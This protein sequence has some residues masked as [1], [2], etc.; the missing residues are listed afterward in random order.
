MRHPLFFAF[1]NALVLTATARIY[2]SCD[3]PIYCE[4]PLLRTV[5]LSNIFT[6][7]KTFVDRPTAKPVEE[8]LKA[9]Q[10]LGK[11]PSVTDVRMFVDENFLEPGMELSQVLIKSNKQPQILERVTD[12]AYSVWMTDLNQYWSNLTYT[13]NTTFLCDGCQ[14]SILPTKR[15]FVVP[16]GRFREFYYWDSY[17]VI[18]GLLYSELN[19][20]ARGMIENFL[21]FVETYGF[22]PNGARIYYLNRSQPPFLTRMIKRYLDFVDDEELFTRALPILDIEYEFWMK[23]TTVEIIDPENDEKHYLNRFNV[24]Y[25]YPRPEAYYEDWHTAHVDKNM[26]DQERV[27]LYSDL[28]T[29]AETGWDYSSRWLRNKNFSGSSQFELLKSLNTRAIVPVELNSLLYDMEVQLSQWNTGKKKAYYQRKAEQRLNS[30]DRLLWNDEYSSFYDFNLTSQCQQIEFTPANYFPFWLGAIPERIAKDNVKLLSVFSELEGILK[31]YPGILTTTLVETGLQWDLP[32]GWPPL[33]YVTLHALLNV[34]KRITENKYTQSLSAQVDSL[35]TVARD[36]ATRY[37]ESGFCGW[38]ATG[39]NVPGYLSNGGHTKDTGHM[40]EKF[41]VTVIGRSGGGGEY[42]PQIGF[43]WT[44]SIAF[45][46]FANFDDFRA[47]NCTLV[48]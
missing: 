43:G 22:L 28:A 10:Q 8:V 5:Q 46:I 13:F 23:N 12:P 39:G 16:G 35:K 44:N 26:T 42:R 17:F 14:T 30:M 41:N 32:N 40:F 2:K 36:L 21:D 11:D 4:G 24:E 38:W 45:W 15:P 3:S 34:H 9:F 29:G 7:S 33:Q 47:P 48:I 1:A 27:D 20:V 18:E 19:D 31:L 37:V 6:D 25:P